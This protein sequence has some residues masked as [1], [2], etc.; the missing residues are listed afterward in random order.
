MTNNYVHSLRFGEEVGGGVWQEMTSAQF[1]F[2]LWLFM[3]THCALGDSGG[4]VRA[5]VQ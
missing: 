5:D 3:S 1:F 2:K 4:M